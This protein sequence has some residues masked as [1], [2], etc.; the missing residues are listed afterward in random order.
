M[1]FQLSYSTSI[2]IS[3][4]QHLFCSC[5][6]P[7]TPPLSIQV[8]DSVGESS[9]RRQLVARCLESLLAVWT[10][11]WCGSERN[12]MMWRG[13]RRVMVRRLGVWGDL[14]TYFPFSIFSFISYICISVAACAYSFWLFCSPRR[15]WR[16]AV[17]A[18]EGT[19]VSVFLYGLKCIVYVAND[20]L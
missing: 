10:T 4:S 14:S 16:C 7:S 2:S 8:F 18:A 12:E 5:L 19:T 1:L 20:Q 6:R 3:V 13:I 17:D 11:G 15:G 9:E